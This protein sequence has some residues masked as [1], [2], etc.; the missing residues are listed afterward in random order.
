MLYG[1]DTGDTLNGGDGDDVILGDNG[2]IT[3]RIKTVPSSYPFDR[4]IDWETFPDPFPEVIRDIQRYDDV[5]LV[6][7]DDIIYGGNENDVLHGQRG[8]DG[9]YGGRSAGLV[10]L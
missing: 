10:M 3:R 4:L 5:D 2:M 6:E 7:G 9:E 8:N 1:S